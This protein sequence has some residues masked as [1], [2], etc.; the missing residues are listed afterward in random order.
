M[1]LKE[2]VAQS[3]LYL[4]EIIKNPV[5]CTEFIQNYDK[6]AYEE[7]FELTQYQKEMMC[8]FNPH[9]SLCSARAIGKTVSLSSLLV[10]ALVYNL[11][12]ND[13]IIFTVPNK[14]HLEP[15]FTNLIRILRSNT[16]LKNFIRSTGGINGSDFTIE[17]LNRAKLMCR[18]AG[19]SGTG[20]N[21]I[22]LHTPLVFLDEA[23]YYPWGTWIEMQPIVNTWVK[24][25]RVMV[26]GVPTGLREKNVL[27]SVDQENSAYTKHR[28]KAFDN[29][30][31]SADDE[32]R[33]EEQY[34]G[35]DSDDY[36]HFV[37]GLHGHPVYALFDRGNFEVGD[38][39]VLKLTLNGLEI[40]ND[41][42]EYMTKIS[43]R[44]PVIQDG[45]PVLIGIDL[46][47]TEPTAIVIMKEDIHDKLHFYA[48]IRMDKVSYPVQEKLIDFIDTR[49]KPQYIGIDKGNIGISMV[50]SFQEGEQ[51]ANK[52]YNTR[53]IPVDFSSSTFIGFDADGAELKQKTKPLAT[54][55]LQDFSNQHKI[56]YSSKDPEMITE[57]ER[58]TYSKSVNG[59]ITYKTMTVRGGQKGEDHFTSAL[60]CAS[61]AYYLTHD[62]T[63]LRTRK[64]KLIGFSWLGA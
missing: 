20:S 36:L 8:D 42:A 18:I 30:R 50:Q 4:Y 54:S 39:D 31:F 52:K 23:G 46:G 3:D 10:W 57:L 17:L 56:V 34:N 21:V 44:I 22:G 12:P 45:S 40:Q 5:L 53:M 14:V 61:L 25:Y 37:L 60:L 19:T 59:D 11:F 1:A 6:V 9:V 7:V 41:L 16:F 49:Y 63:L 15:V 43:S 28:V 51:Y 62:F 58:M 27:Y 35:K 26:S 2:H 64:P 38:D 29:P 24:G 32:E 13:Y 55:I 33:A 48:R 47:Y